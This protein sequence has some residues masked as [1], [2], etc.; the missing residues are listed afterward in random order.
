[1]SVPDETLDWKEEPDHSGDESES[2]LGADSELVRI[3]DRYL[4]DLQAG[5][6]PDRAQ[7]LADHPDLADQLESCLAGIDF[8]HRTTGVTDR[9]ET[10][11]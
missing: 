1:M 10:A 5:R 11:A 8:I 6:A 4:A 3:L 2:S 7:V 9:G